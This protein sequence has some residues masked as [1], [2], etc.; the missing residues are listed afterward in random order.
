[1]F[2]FVCYLNVFLTIC[3]A[4]YCETYLGQYIFFRMEEEERAAGPKA[5]LCVIATML[6]LCY[7]YYAIVLLCVIARHTVDCLLWHRWNL[8][9][10]NWVKDAVSFN[11]CQLCRKC[12]L[13]RELE[14]ICNMQFC[15]LHLCVICLL[16][17]GAMFS[18]Y[19]VN[20]SVCILQCTFYSV[21]FT[22]CIWLCTFYNVHFTVCRSG[23]LTCR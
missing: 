11:C 23:S 4:I 2:L 14:N 10:S 18:F 1:M 12:A 15:S 8:D 5:L 7:C 6:L 19:C 3:V 13:C 22:G 16:L 20:F 17:C 9:I 21:Y